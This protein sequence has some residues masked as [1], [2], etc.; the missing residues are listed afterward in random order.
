M[1]NSRVCTECGKAHAFPIP[2]FMFGQ[3]I[4]MVSDSGYHHKD[5][6]GQIA[7]ILEVESFLVMPC[8]RVEYKTTFGLGNILEDRLSST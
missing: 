4:R 2:K 8:D 5:K 3:Q 1:L 6:V 7:T